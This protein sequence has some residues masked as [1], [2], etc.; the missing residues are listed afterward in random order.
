LYQIQIYILD[1]KNPSSV[2]SNFSLLISSILQFLFRITYYLASFEILKEGYE[3]INSLSQSVALSFFI[4]LYNTNSEN[5]K[6]NEEINKIFLNSPVYNAI[7]DLFYPLPFSSSFLSFLYSTDCLSILTSFR[8]D[9]WSFKKFSQHISSDI[10]G[11]IVE[12][13]SQDENIIDSQSVSSACFQVSNSDSLTSSILTPI[14]IISQINVANF[15]QLINILIKI[16]NNI[17]LIISEGY[18]YYFFSCNFC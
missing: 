18:F 8:N 15:K 16:K 2:I 1:G 12:P 5:E 14:N 11:T 4:L 13:L 17:E 6:N 7:L 3:T 9:K 10:V